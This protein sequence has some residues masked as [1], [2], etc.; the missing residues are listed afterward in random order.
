VCCESV[1]LRAVAAPV[2]VGQCKAEVARQGLDVCR[3]CRSS[4]SIVGGAVSVEA[5]CRGE[6]AGCERERLARCEPAAAAEAAGCEREHRD[7]L[8]GCGQ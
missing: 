2:D 6:Q 4:A 8:R 5:D 3:R 1:C 7:C